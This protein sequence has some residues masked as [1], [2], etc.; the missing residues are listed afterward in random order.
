MLFLL[1]ACAP[2]NLQTDHNTAPI[3]IFPL[4]EDEVAVDVVFQ[5]A[6]PSEIES[7]TIAIIVWDDQ[8]IE[9]EYVLLES[10]GEFFYQSQLDYEPG[11]E[12][13]WTAWHYPVGS[14][15]ER[16]TPQCFYVQP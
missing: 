8:N 4:D 10:T 6:L 1:L 5:G 11:V 14:L 16:F 15:G 3:A 12:Y 9:Q 7:G 13:C 2:E